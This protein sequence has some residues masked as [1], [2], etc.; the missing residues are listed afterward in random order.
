MAYIKVLSHQ[1]PGGTEENHENHGLD[2]RSPGQDSNPAFG[3][4]HE[5]FNYKRKI[6]YTL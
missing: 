2:N 1:F 3:I 5:N 4:R 6:I